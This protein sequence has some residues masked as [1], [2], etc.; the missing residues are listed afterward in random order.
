M[1]GPAGWCRGGGSLQTSVTAAA[2]PAAAVT[3]PSAPAWRCPLPCS[4]NK[5]EEDFA[6]KQEFDD[7]LEER[8]DI[9]EHQLLL[10]PAGT[11][12]KLCRRL[13]LQLAERPHWRGSP[14]QPPPTHLCNCLHLQS[15]T[16]W[17]ESM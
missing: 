9:S 10:L 12:R 11:G 16:L 13:P 6:T 3:R 5:R 7:Y 4:F 1:A 15:S 2:A 8:E 14:H 17:R